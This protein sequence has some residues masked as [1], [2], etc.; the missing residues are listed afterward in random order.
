[1]ESSLFCSSD[2]AER[3]DG[4]DSSDG[5][6][7]E[8]GLE[9]FAVGS[10]RKIGRVDDGAPFFPIGADIVGIGWNFQAITDWK[11][12]TGALEHFFGFVER[13]D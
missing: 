13:V 9:D 5:S 7:G 10:K 8:A 3:V 11:C 4:G 6:C 1:L 2:R 12:R